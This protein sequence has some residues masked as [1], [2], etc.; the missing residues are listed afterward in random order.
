MSKFKFRLSTL[1]RLREAARDE[2]RAELAEAYRVDDTLRQQLQRTDQELQSL[3]A[4]RRQGMQPGAVDVDRLV[5]SQRYEMTL[6]A[7]RLQIVR[8][9]ETVQGEIER[10]RQV[11]AEANRDLRV[12]ENLRDKQ[13][14]QHRQQE[15]R[16]EMKRID[17]VAQ[18]QAL[19][20]AT[21]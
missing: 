16:R 7:Q 18:Q 8:Q 21:R 3:R 15:E 11:L 2:R 9:R 12:L 6:S 4:Q 20:E 13:A 1:L 17:E 10:R 19:R 14:G 5:E